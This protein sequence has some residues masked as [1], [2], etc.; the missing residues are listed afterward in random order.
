MISVRFTID[1]DGLYRGFTVEGHAG[2][3]DAGEDIICAAVSALAQNTV[4]SIEAFTGDEFTCDVDDGYLSV[5]FPKKLSAES[6]LL[7]NSL[8][9]GL[10]NIA[11]AYGT[12][13]LEI[14]TEE[15]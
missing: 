4:N 5:E 3:A 14:V 2:Y 11:E 1:S 12:E 7:M 15:V 9:L 6:K 13:W 8:N 10:T